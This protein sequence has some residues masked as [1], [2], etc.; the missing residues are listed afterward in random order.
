MALADKAWEPG[1]APSDAGVFGRRARDQYAAM[2]AM[3]ARIF[4]NRFRTL[5]GAF[6]LGARTVSFFIYC[7]MGLS[8]GA[9]AGAVAYSLVSSRRWQ[10]LALEFWVISFLWVAISIA[11]ASFQEQYDMSGLLHF[12]VNFRSFYFLHLIFGLIDVSTIVG[13]L[14]CLGMLTA[15]TIVRPD[16][17]GAMLAALA[18]LA[19]FNILLARAVLAWIDR[20]LA[21][22]RSREIVSALF[23]LAM[24]CLQLL[25]PLLRNQEHGR[26]GGRVERNLRATSL[27]RETPPWLVDLGIVQRW[28]PPGLA[29]NVPR[30]FEDHEPAKAGA[31][32]GGLVIFTLAAGGFLAVR[33]RAEF[34]GENLGESPGRHAGRESDSNWRIVGSGPLSAQ[35]EKEL[36][37]MLRSLTQLYS[38]GVPML[39]VFVIA[40]LFRNGATVAREPVHLAL[41]VSVAYGLLGFTQLMYNNLGA[42]G[43][44]IQ[45][46][47]L[48]PVRMR[49][50][51]LGKNLFHGTLYLLVAMVSASL[52]AL[53]MGPP[54]ALLVITT[55][56][57]LAFALPANLAAGNILSLT[58]AY[59]VNLGRIGRQSGSQANA[60]VSMVIQ[61]AILGIGA[62]VISLANIFDKGWVAPPVLA[63]FACAACLAWALV[64]RNADKIANARRDSLITKLAR[65]E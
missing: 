6:E 3:L 5:S 53:R 56:C 2:A 62:V 27:P 24:V 13:V 60:L 25:N 28:L 23:V 16:L 47:F 7:L 33:L 54:D 21:K 50:V 52:A 37:T 1:G 18:G 55:L 26:H 10:S 35:I 39:M 51:L 34:R 41:P 42:E 19:A 8:L 61:A 46:L 31:S 29:A 30:S 40:S 20:W 58:M 22:R 12:P 38:V 64:L 48:F 45:M 32:I 17:F 36:R 63:V 14:C 65:I 43:K 49:T 4:M 9:G 59:R 57:W 11:L 44:G 15:S